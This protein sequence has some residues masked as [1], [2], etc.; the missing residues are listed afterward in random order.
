[1]R[2]TIEW[3]MAKAKISEFQESEVEL[4]ELAKAIAHPARIR[5]LN[6]LTECDTCITGS[7]VDQLPLSQSTVSQHLAELKK[8]GLIEGKI[9]G[10]KTCYCLNPDNVLK[11]KNAFSKLFSTICKC[12]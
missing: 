2:Y 4:A 1:M 7:I 12:C 3:G 8:A 9:E 11:A 6:I 10:P 5:I